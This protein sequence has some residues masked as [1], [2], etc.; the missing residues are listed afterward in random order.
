MRDLRTR[1]TRI[2]LGRAGTESSRSF[3]DRQ[4]EGMAP[5]VI[6]AT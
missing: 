4:A 1:A 5:D 2:Y 3:F 6:G